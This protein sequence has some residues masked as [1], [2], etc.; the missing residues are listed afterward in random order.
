MRHISLAVGILAAVSL[1]A[2]GF[3]CSK[4]PAA[5]QPVVK[6]Q[7][8]N[9]EAKAPVAQ[10]AEPQAQAKRVE[11]VALY[12]P[13]GKRDPFVSFIKVEELRKTGIG[14][15]MLP[16]LQ[17]YDLGELK[18][19]GVIW[20]K[21][22]ALGLVEDAEGKGYSVTVGTR[23]GRSGGVVSRITGKEILVK[24]EF[25]GNRGEK[26]VKESGIQLTTA[27]GK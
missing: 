26:I 27:G 3:G 4:E 15:A 8:P 5:P 16:P 24:E 25:V 22:G 23:I 12:D 13:R 6:R 20:T 18:F 14:T 7:A 9:P 17:R 19:V 10:A 11:P 1:F 2:G 21:K